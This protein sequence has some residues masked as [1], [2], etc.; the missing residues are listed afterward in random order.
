MLDKAI[1]HPDEDLKPAVLKYDEEKED[2]VVDVPK[3]ITRVD[4]INLV[5]EIK[6]LTEWED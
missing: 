3:G 4:L 2:Y 1:L 6:R 5:E